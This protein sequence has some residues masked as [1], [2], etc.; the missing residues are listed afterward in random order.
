M[1]LSFPGE[2]IFSSSVLESAYTTNGNE[3]KRTEAALTSSGR[4]AIEIL[5]FKEIFE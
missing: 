4:S 2:G 3:V 1:A 5:I